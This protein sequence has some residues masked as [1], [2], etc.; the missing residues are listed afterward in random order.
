MRKKL[1]FGL[2]AGLLTLVLSSCWALQN[3]TIGDYTLTPGQSTKAKLTLRPMGSAYAPVFTGARQFV[4]IGVGA[5]NIGQDTDIGVSNAI[6]GVNGQLGGPLPMGIENNLVTA[7]GT[8]CSASG[9]NFADIS[10]VVWKAFATPT[11]KNDGGKV[12]KQS[13]IQVTLKAKAAA[14]DAGENYAIMGVVGAW[15]DD[16]DGNPEASGAGDAYQCWGIS[17][18]SV[19]SL[20]GA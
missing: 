7:L 12:E 4:I 9:L 20:G 2:G 15:Q 1:S 16:G 13:V 6:W 11:N 8:D 3:F 10:G 18:A 14:V 17:T 19:H 5:V